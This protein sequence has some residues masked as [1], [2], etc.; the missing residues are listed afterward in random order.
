[1]ISNDNF[2]FTE[3]RPNPDYGP[4]KYELNENEVLDLYYAEPR[5]A[6]LIEM[7]MM[8]GS[9]GSQQTFSSN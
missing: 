8:L 1:M 3:R 2:V 6:A 4:V 9:K 7:D 5:L